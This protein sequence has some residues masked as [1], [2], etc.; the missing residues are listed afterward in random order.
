MSKDLQPQQSEEVDL[1]Q[2]FKLI[3]NGFDRFFRFIGSI[4]YKLFLVF[5]WLVFF[6]KKHYIKLAIAGVVGIALGVF[7]EKTSDPVYKSH[8]TVKQNYN[9]G[10]NLYN[11]ISYYNDL[12]AQEDISTL[13]T[14]LGIKSGVAISILSFDIESRT[15][16]NQK[17]KAFDDY[18]KKLD[19]AIASKMEYK[20]YIKNSK[21]YDHQY[22]QI[23]I[24][25]LE[26][27]N[28]KT[29]F[30]KI[31]GNINS[32]TYF[33][34]EQ[35]KDLKELNLKA[36][37]IRE[38][39]IKSDTLLAIY[40]KAIIKSAERNN[41]FAQIT[42]SDKGKGSST[43]E[44]ELYTKELGLRQNLVDIE[45]EIDDKEHIIE[46]TSTRQD[47]GGVDNKKHLFGGDVGSKIFYCF[48]L[49]S[50]TF[51]VLFG[52]RLIKFLERYK[53]KI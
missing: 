45:R 20:T 30:D 44:F 33:K 53:E 42:I 14:A 13:E 36:L 7:Q 9:T 40:Q 15:S 19:T 6:V 3:G 31:I 46:I 25:A 37:A 23:T 4:F 43:K 16:E 51:I 28:F 39:L 48:I 50:L 10:E 47:K 22:Q 1:G 49:I 5:V 29:I 24:W 8:I 17:L 41:D 21:E 11:T 2:L 38:S 34:R 52:L 32:N 35:D 27:T 12:L 26:R 18:L